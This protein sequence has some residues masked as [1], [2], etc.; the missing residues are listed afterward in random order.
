M[1]SLNEFYEK[2][3]KLKE[4]NTWQPNIN[5]AKIKEIKEILAA[6]D[7]EISKKVNEILNGVYKEVEIAINELKT[8]NRDADFEKII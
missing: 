7:N 2:Y 1:K 3:R 5:E 8:N 4:S 6:M